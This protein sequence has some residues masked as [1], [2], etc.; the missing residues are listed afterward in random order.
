M[1]APSLFPWVS[2]ISQV[3]PN[4]INVSLPS[5]GYLGNQAQLDVVNVCPGFAVVENSLMAI[6]LVLCFHHRLGYYIPESFWALYPVPSVPT[7]FL[8][9]ISFCLSWVW[10]LVKKNHL[11]LI[12]YN[13]TVNVKTGL[14]ESSNLV[15]LQDCVGWL[16]YVFFF[17]TR[18]LKSDYS[19]NR[20]ICLVFYCCF[21]FEL[22]SLYIAQSGLEPVASVLSAFMFFF[23][24]Y[25]KFIYINSPLTVL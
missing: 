16:F 22:G 4:R 11:V 19:G 9:I 13:F 14:C 20:I 3:D 6:E 21:H 18:A 1:F 2:V 8:L 25:S 10:S 23:N 12:I 15:Y 5:S 17:S 7:S 24:R